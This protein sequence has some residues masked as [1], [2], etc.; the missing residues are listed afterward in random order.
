MLKFERISSM[1][2]VAVYSDSAFSGV[3]IKKIVNYGPDTYVMCI[4]NYGQ[5][6][7][8][9]VKVHMTERPY[10]VLFGKRIH[11]DECMRAGI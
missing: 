6:R 10:F 3:E 8:H 9:R 5:K 4:S 1:P 7:A 11:L 2:T